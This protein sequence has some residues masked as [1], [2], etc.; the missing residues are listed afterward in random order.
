M[1]RLAITSSCRAN[2][3]VQLAYGG[4]VLIRRL[5]SGG[6]LE[7]ALDCFDGAAS[8]LLVTFAD[9]NTE[10]RPVVAQDLDKL[11]KVAVI[12][13]APVNLDL[14]AFEYSAGIGK[15]G[16]VWERAASM[17]VTAREIAAGSRRGRGYL[18]TGDDG[19]GLGDKLEVYTFLHQDEQASGV[20]AMGLDYET[21]GE[22][23]SGMTC[24][25]GAFAAIRYQVVTRGRRGQTARENGILSAAPCGAKIGSQ[26]RFDPF[27][28][29]A[30]RVQQ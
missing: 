17:L 8:D 6:H 4:A 20:V 23:P 10:R 15:A 30:I 14:H 13:S 12:W 22:V 11:S 29:P 19:R 7:F 26:V 24:G 3:D 2:Q 21:R 16:H 28:L 27:L 5:D 1:M 9:G 18:S 25:N